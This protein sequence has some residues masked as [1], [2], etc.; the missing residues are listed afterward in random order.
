MS[1]GGGPVGQV[2]SEV[3]KNVKPSCRGFPVLLF[4]LVQLSRV[5]AACSLLCLFCQ[6]VDVA[7][8]VCFNILFSSLLASVSS[9]CV[10]GALVRLMFIAGFFSFRTGILRQISAVFQSFCY[11]FIRPPASWQ[12]DVGVCLMLVSV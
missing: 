12:I 6:T 3:F 4:L 5:S 9:S 10:F 7:A 2:C 1:G 8:F 11:G